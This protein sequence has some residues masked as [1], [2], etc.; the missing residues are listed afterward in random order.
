M[1]I[2]NPHIVGCCGSLFGSLQVGQATLLEVIS[3]RGGIVVGSM[4]DYTSTGLAPLCLYVLIETQLTIYP[5][6]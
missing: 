1:G 2:G 6:A 4:G 5:A 3:I